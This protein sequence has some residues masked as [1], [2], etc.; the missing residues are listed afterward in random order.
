M[1]KYIILCTIVLIL[2]IT[3]LFVIIKFRKKMSAQILMLSVAV[4]GIFMIA[5]LYFMSCLSFWMTG[6]DETYSTDYYE[7]SYS[8]KWKFEAYDKLITNVSYD[9]E[10]IGDITVYPQSAYADSLSYI[11][12]NIYGTHAYLKEDLSIEDD[13]SDLTY[14]IVVGYE[15]SAADELK[16]AEEDSDEIHYLYVEQDNTVIDLCVP[17]SLEE[18]IQEI[19]YDLK[20]R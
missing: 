12:S 18:K 3:A 2:L 13:S 9:G 6:D 17:C 7:I 10:F 4:I 20:V 11:I 1:Q 5:D 14:C 15:Q 8:E 16:D 19:V